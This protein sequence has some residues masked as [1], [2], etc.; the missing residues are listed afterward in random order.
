MKL[1]T[2]NRNYLFLRAYKSRLN[3][4]SPLIVTYIVKKKSGG[5]R[6]GIT[7]GKKVGCAVDRNRARRVVKAAATELLRNTAGNYDIVVVCR[8]LSC[9][10]SGNEIKEDL[11]EHLSSA[12]VIE[13]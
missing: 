8:H 7:A 11:R 2:I 3:Y 13:C 5:L 1:E 6:I 10:V 4:V 12:G 9:K